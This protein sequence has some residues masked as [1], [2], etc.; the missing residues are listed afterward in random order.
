MHY[1]FYEYMEKFEVVRE[2]KTL[3]NSDIIR[4]FRAFHSGGNLF[5]CS[6]FQNILEELMLYAMFSDQQIMDFYQELTA[7][8]DLSNFKLIRFAVSLSG[9]CPN[10]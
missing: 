10:H 6:F 7:L 9:K 5:E 4:R 3:R 2:E 8:L 1:D